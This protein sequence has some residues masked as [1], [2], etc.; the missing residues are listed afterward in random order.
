[1]VKMEPTKP[2]NVCVES[3]N[4]HQPLERFEVRDMSLSVSSRTP[5]RLAR[6]P[7]LQPNQ[8]TISKS[9]QDA[10]FALLFGLEE[11]TL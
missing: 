6:P 4:E 2:V 1:M 5:S 11:F 3:F 8:E 7:N 10:C 9:M